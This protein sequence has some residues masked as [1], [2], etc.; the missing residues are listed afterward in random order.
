M[1]TATI[2]EKLT[3][4]IQTADDKKIEAIY[5]IIEDEIDTESARKALIFAERN[6][7]LNNEGKSFSWD[8]VKSMAINKDKRNGL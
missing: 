5:T 2:R 8:E 7:Y 4:Y 6:N 3:Q 1:N